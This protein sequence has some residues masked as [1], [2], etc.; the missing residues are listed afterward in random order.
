MPGLDSCNVL[1][2]DDEEDILFL[3]KHLL[4]PEVKEVTTTTMPQ[5]ILDDHFED[6]DLVFLDMN[7]DRQQQSGDDGFRWLKAIKDMRPQ[8]K[9]V[10]MTSYGDI[11]MAV[12]A[13]KEGATDFIL[14]PL[15][16]DKLM[17]TLNKIYGEPDR[18]VSPNAEIKVSNSRRKII[19]VSD[20]MEKLRL[21]IVKV[22]KTDAS[23]LIL[24]ENGVGKDIVAEEIHLH[25]SR[26]SSPFVSVD[27]GSLSE[28]L[29]ESEMF[30]HNRGAYTGANE[31]RKGRFECAQ[32]G[33]LFLDEIGNLPLALQGKLLTAL[34]R[35][36]ITP[37]GSNTSIHL[38]VRVLAATNQ[39]VYDMCEQGTF[40]QDLIYRLNTITLNVPPLRERPEDIPVLLDFWLEVYGEKY[41]KFGR[42]ISPSTLKTLQACEWPGNI[43]ELMHC[44]EGALIMSEADQLGDDDFRSMPK[45][46]AGESKLKDLASVEKIA[47]QEAI[48]AN[49]GNLSR[50]A[51][52]LSISR[53][54]LYRKMDKLGLKK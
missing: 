8:V 14:K 48:S 53:F 30:G 44:V 21:D 31:K 35:K 6:I 51:E 5:A 17:K 28:T 11:E 18:H 19:G 15:I 7:F 54:Q 12:R 36:T 34:Q 40:R 39:N 29:F 38:D 45:R 27:V 25:S 41:N 50:A 32:H 37:V 24:G 47:I 10:C 52:A 4:E 9:I 23:V 13:V 16:K 20:A 3:A 42:K 43:R 1:V 2:C 22:A 33:T 46:R 26:A 49:D